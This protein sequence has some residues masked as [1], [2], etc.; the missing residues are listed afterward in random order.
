MMPEALFKCI[1]SAWRLNDV[2][3]LL[4]STGTTLHTVPNGV[5][6]Q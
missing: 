3:L 6:L 1:F 4:T 2:S 5:T